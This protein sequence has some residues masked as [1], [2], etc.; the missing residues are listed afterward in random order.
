MSRD[1]GVAI[2]HEIAIKV[3]GADLDEKTIKSIFEVVVDSTL[4]LPNMVT[5]RAYD[6]DLELIDSNTFPLGGEIQV[7]SFDQ[8]RA[9]VTIFK[10][11]ITA[12]EPEFNVDGAVLSVRGY[13]KSHRLN[14]ETKT[15]AYVNS[16][17]SDIVRQLVGSAGLTARIDE[18]NQVHEH[19]Y[20]DNQTDFEF[21]QMLA[22][23]NG[24][25]V[26]VD[27]NTLH[28]R[29]PSTSGNTITLK[30]GETLVNFRPRLSLAGQVNEV[31][32]KG[33]DPK[34][35]RSII[36]TATTSSTAPQVGYGK[37]GGQAAQSTF[38]A[39]KHIEVRRPVESQT[40]ADAMAQAILDEINAGFLQAEG[41]AFGVPQLI[42]GKIAKIEGVGTT[43]GGKYVVTSARHIFTGG[44][45]NVEFT[46][47]GP[48][49]QMMADLLSS[50]GYGTH[51]S[52]RWGG[53]VTALVTNL[54]DP[55]KQGRVKLKFP[56]LADS[57]ESS[58]ARVCT[59]GVGEAQGGI[60][61]LP[62]VND[63]VLVAFE[64]GDF[65]HPYVLGGVWNGQNKP[66]ET[67]VQNGKT[68][69]RT[70]RTRSGHIIR[71]TDKDG[72]QKIELIDAQNHTSIIM[73]TQN[74][75]I[76]IKSEDKIDIL[77]AGDILIKS[78]AKLNIESAQAMTIK[79]QSVDIQATNG[80]VNIKGINVNAD[81]SAGAKLKGGATADVEGATVSIKGT[82]V[83][84]LN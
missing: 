5:L 9:A 84:K 55:E 12:L 79:G 42:A 3:G 10:G 18:T 14:R 33:W 2:V 56:W 80:D 48:R 71:M 29:K 37:S 64:L 39:A 20:Q 57:E 70:I 7:D 53:V 43:F 47:E 16:K 19:I 22:R 67:D 62:E 76:T 46:V 8:R 60:Q 13:D 75:K 50:N 11:E 78:D 25:E 41:T 23:R 61:W 82:A 24:R 28:F 31:T 15:K 66:P 21:I 73:D 59:P 49:R 38:S 81:G 69:I 51:S 77:A 68:E 54:D 44:E 58:W 30:W 35:K 72:E 36:G 83:V 27:G 40:E 65:N 34:Q 45:M 52:N 4:S 6:P 1:N 74:K 32:V 26:Q 63:E 17:D